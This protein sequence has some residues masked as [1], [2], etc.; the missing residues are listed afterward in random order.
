VISRY[1]RAG[2][3]G[4]SK[5]K[6]HCRD[7][8]TGVADLVVADLVVVGLFIGVSLLSVGERRVNNL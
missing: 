2:V 7:L 1:F 8:T 4:S 6:W 3:A 5:L